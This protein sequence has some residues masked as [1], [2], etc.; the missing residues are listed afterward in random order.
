MTSYEYHDILN[1]LHLDYLFNN[2]F[3]LTSKEASKLDITSLCE[4]NPLVTSGFLSQRA[5]D[6]ESFSMSWCLNALWKS[7]DGTFSIA[8]CNWIL[9]THYITTVATVEQGSLM[10]CTNTRHPISCSHRLAVAFHLA[11]MQLHCNAI[12]NLQISVQVEA[13]IHIFAVNNIDIPPLPPTHLAWCIT[14]IH[15]YRAVFKTTIFTSWPKNVPPYLISDY[16]F[17]CSG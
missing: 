15:V 6:A 13:M 8:N 10:L 12:C 11:I 14:W 16:N 3:Q 2:L 1:H 9:H 4:G 17:T 5:S 7:H